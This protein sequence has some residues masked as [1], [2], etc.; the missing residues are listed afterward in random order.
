MSKPSHV[1]VRMCIGCTKRAAQPSLLRIKSNAEGSLAVASENGLHGR[2]A[3]LHPDRNCWA[4]FAARK[5]PVRSLAR[6]VGKDERA[7]LVKLLAA[8]ITPQSEVTGHVA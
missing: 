6:S 4:Q 1:P 8:S 3:Y 7:A 5:G 2:S